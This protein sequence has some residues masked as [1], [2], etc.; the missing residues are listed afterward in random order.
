MRVRG[1]RG[2]EIAVQ[3]SGSSEA[4]AAPLD[5]IIETTNYVVPLQNFQKFPL[6]GP[7]R[8]VGGSWPGFGDPGQGSSSGT[9]QGRDISWWHE[10]CQMGTNFVA[11]QC[12]INQQCEPEVESQNSEVMW[13]SAL[14]I[15]VKFAGSCVEVAEGMAASSAS[16]WNQRRRRV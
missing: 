14:D 1:V 5:D 4:N 6:E 12:A 8:A 3:I 7:V 16:Y 2:R 13:G 9:G 11:A 15:M 10:Y